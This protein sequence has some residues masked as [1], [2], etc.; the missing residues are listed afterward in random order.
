MNV[1]ISGGF[2]GWHVYSYPAPTECT[3]DEC[4]TSHPHPN[5]YWKCSACTRR[6]WFESK[7]CTFKSGKPI[8]LSLHAT[9]KCIGW[10]RR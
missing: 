4:G 9:L 1:G 8:S 5:N 2:T 7:I 10:F 3:D 6:A